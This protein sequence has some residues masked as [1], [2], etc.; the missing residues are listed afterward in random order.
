MKTRERRKLS[1]LSIDQELKNSIKSL[2]NEN[3]KLKIN[4]NREKCGK[5]YR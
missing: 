2:L 3:I 4:K 1:N 5:I